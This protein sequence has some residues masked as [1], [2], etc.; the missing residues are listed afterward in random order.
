MGLCDTKND[1]SIMA[2]RLHRNNLVTH[3]QKK[4]RNGKLLFIAGI[5][6]ITAALRIPFL[7]LPF[8]RDEGGYA[9]IASRLDAHEL[10][11]RDW[12]DQ[13]PPGIFWIYRAAL[14]LPLE[15]VRAVHL[16]AILVSAASSC[17]LFF[18]ARRFVSS[19][20]AFSA[21]AAFALFS[22]DPFIE[23]TAANTEI[24]MLLP[25][26]LSQIVFLRVLDKTSHRIVLIVLC[27]ALIGIAT[28]F[29]QVAA[30]NWPLLIGLFP[31]LIAS[32]DRWRRTVRF[33]A[34]L[35]LG[36]LTVW[37]VVAV[38][39]WWHDALTQFLS[40]AF[41]YNFEY[42]SSLNW[43]DR[44]RLSSETLTRLAHS[45]LF[46][47]ILSATGLVAAFYRRENISLLFVGGWIAAS[48]V[49]VGAS[50]YFFPHYFQ[51][52]L[53][54][55]ILAAVIGAQWLE[56]S[57]RWRN[58][59]IPRLLLTVILVALSL[60][61]SWPFWFAYSPAEAAQ[62]I[63]PGDFVADMR[64]IAAR[65]AELTSSD[66]RVFVFGAEPEVFF[67]AHRVSATRYIFIFPLYGLHRQVHE[68]QIAAIAEIEKAVPAAAVYL[69]NAR[70]FG[71]DTDQSFTTWALS[72][73]EQ[74]FTPDTWL[75]AESGTVAGMI[76]SQISP[77][78]PPNTIGAIFVRK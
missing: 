29:K 62:K 35:T 3:A 47:W 45:E 55:L 15:S 48:L 10:P 75:V 17:A 5:V 49:A 68:R 44:W 65:V 7:D 76:S 66:R 34:W 72:Y 16:V 2:C 53:P 73:L 33:G 59:W 28:I 20:W 14:T 67:Y 50:G 41:A 22:A 70:F 37:W 26:L 57:R 25:L 8:E 40:T 69:P 39:F 21:S 27:G 11:Y 9:Y 38:Y 1:E 52:L 56:Q 12:I 23:G 54:P 24:F 18:L 60:R 77:A 19:F 13:K 6:L 36:V 64:K 74:N 61:A 71:R 32:E 43:T 63:Y 58:I 42:V 31:I 4:F 78:P 46:L 51:Q 30:V